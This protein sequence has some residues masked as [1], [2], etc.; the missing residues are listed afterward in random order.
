M[1]EFKKEKTNMKKFLVILL[2]FSLV[3]SMSAVAFADPDVNDYG[4]EPVDVEDI[5]EAEEGYQQIEAVQGFVIPEPGHVVLSPQNLMIDGELVDVQAYN[6]DGYNYFRLRDIAALLTGTGSQFNVG[7]V[8]PNIVVT[9][10]EAYTPIAGDL[11]AGEDL[12]ATTVPS[13]QILYVDGA[14]VEILVYNIGGNNFFQLRGLGALVGFEVDFDEATNTIVVET[15]E[16]QVTFAD[17]PEE[18]R[19]LVDHVQ[20]LVIYYAEQI[21]AEVGDWHVALMESGEG[22]DFEGFE[23]IRE[24]LAGFR[25]SSG[26]RFL[27]LMY[28]TGD[29]VNDDVSFILTVDSSGITDF[30]TEYGFEIQFRETWLGVPSP[31]RSAWEDH[32]VPGEFGYCWTAFAPIFD[33]EGNVVALLGI[34][35]PAPMMV[36]FPEWNRN[37][38]LWN[39][40]IE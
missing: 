3:F 15:A 34:D 5:E 28:P 2:A 7:F 8:A 6:I 22:A 24:L 4:Y 13:A 21:P 1:L 23:E 37:H 9:T 10:G 39:G 38:E 19:A 27:Y 12:S 36:D 31:A 29:I 18:L 16:A 32:Y 33:S 26:A 30:G 14:R 35:Y 40:I 11:V 20:A 25:I 17:L